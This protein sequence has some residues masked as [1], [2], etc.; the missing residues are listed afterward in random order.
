MA[1]TP[2]VHCNAANLRSS[3][4]SGANPE[5]EED[6]LDMDEDGTSLWAGKHRYRGGRHGYNKHHYGGYNKHQVTLDIPV[7]ITAKGIWYL[8]F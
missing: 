1:S 4:G 2:D 8:V 6:L 5:V 7:R 3:S